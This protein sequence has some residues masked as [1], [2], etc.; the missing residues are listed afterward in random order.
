[1]VVRTLIATKYNSTSPECKW[2]LT[3]DL[4]DRVSVRKRQG[5]GRVL[6]RYFGK[7]SFC[8]RS[9]FSY[10]NCNNC[11]ATAIN[12]LVSSMISRFW[13]REQLKSLCWKIVSCYNIK[14]IVYTV[15]RSLFTILL[16]N[17]LRGLDYYYFFFGIFSHLEIRKV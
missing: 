13:R 10:N 5:I 3:C 6:L 15:T 12:N 11:S 1:M 14:F 9:N 16:T 17:Q 8:R 7:G 4:W 2:N